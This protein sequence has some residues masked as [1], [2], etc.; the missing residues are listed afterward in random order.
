MAAAPLV[1]EG[2]VTANVKLKV[3]CDKIAKA[4]CNLDREPVTA[5]LWVYAQVGCSMEMNDGIKLAPGGSLVSGL[6]GTLGEL[7]PE[8]G[9]ITNINITPTLSG[10]TPGSLEVTTRPGYITDVRM[11]SKSTTPR[12]SSSAE[13]TAP[14]QVGV[15][16]SVTNRHIVVNR[17]ND[18]DPGPTACGG[19]VAIRMRAQGLVRTPTSVDTLDMFGDI[20]SL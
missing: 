12:P 5:S 6:P 3:D 9:D 18:N 1:R 20:Y 7:L 11:G 17:R 4:D 14:R 10:L 2:F 19:P 8:G 15:A 16:V 13:V